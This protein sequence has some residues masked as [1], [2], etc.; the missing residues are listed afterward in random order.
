M[1]ARDDYSY[2]IMRERCARLQAKQSDDPA[3]RQ[4]HLQFAAAYA[5]RARAEATRR[6][7]VTA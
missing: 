3:I 6:P 5:R 4:I 1:P 2:F 7:A